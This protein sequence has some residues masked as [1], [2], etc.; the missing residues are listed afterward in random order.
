MIQG[1]KNSGTEDI[2]NGT[3][4]KE[5][6]RTCPIELWR[7]ATRKLDQLDSVVSL[8]DLRIPPGNRLEALKHKRKGQHSIRI[9]DQ[10]RICFRWTESGPDAVEIVDYHE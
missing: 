10:Y 6:R 3:E 2:F 9:N 8:N 7:I 4:T 1:F 5:A